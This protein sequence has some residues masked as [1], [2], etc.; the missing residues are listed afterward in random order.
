MRTGK[1]LRKGSSVVSIGESSMHSEGWAQKRCQNAQ[2]ISSNLAS[3]PFYS[4]YTSFPVLGRL[5]PYVVL[6][7][8][9]LG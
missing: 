6:V 4:K 9:V 5:K 2:V 7:L 3:T 8:C 1:G